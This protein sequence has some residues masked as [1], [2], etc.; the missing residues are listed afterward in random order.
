MSQE[1][2]LREYIGHGYTGLKKAADAAMKG[3][4]AVFA[5]QSGFGIGRVEGF[6]A[7]GTG[8]ELQVRGDSNLSKVSEYF[9]QQEQISQ[10][11]KQMQVL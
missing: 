9:V 1:Q 6:S 4:T 3:A 8:T 5:V 7:P 11:E 2:K 10:A